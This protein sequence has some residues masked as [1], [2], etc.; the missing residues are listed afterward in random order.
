M[1]LTSAV[2]KAQLD[3]VLG[4][5]RQHVCAAAGTLLF[6]HHDLRRAPSTAVQVHDC[7]C[8][9]FTTLNYVPIQFD[10]NIGVSMRSTSLARRTC[11]RR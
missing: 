7:P 3:D 4:Q 2:V 5:R 8:H 1:K 9:S 10:R 6:G 11:Y